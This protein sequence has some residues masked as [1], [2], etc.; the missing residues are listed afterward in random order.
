[1][2]QGTREKRRGAMVQTGL[3]ESE[4][5]DGLAPTVSISIPHNQFPPLSLVHRLER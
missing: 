4:S 1:M 5:Q 2:D 3:S